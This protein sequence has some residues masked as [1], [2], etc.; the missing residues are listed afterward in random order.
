MSVTPISNIQ[1]LTPVLDFKQVKS[2]GVSPS[3]SFKNMLSDLINDVNKA[4]AAVTEDIKRI[5][6][7]NTDNLHEIMINAQKAE[8][9]ILTAVQVRNKVLDAY[10]EIMN[11]NL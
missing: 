3:L 8:L 5:A 2:Q 10:K 4:E 11:I 9:S 1:S 6:S 7:G